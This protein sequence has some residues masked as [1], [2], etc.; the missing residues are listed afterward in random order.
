[1]TEKKKDK[2]DR[3]FYQAIGKK[4][5]KAT[6]ERHGSKHFQEAGRLGG[7]TLLEE[8]GT[9]Y[10]QAIGRLRHAKKEAPDAS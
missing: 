10:F 5:G 2:R 1:M 9:E 4:G 7:E 8:R 3:A 6:R